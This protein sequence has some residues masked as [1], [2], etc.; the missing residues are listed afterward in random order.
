M[1]RKRRSFEVLNCEVTLTV[2]KCIDFVKKLCERKVTERV[3][4]TLSDESADKRKHVPMG[5]VCRKVC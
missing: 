5:A 2:K 4:K 1:K 3:L